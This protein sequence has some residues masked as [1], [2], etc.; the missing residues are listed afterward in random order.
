MVY[1]T[2]PR[3]ADTDG[4]GLSDAVELASGSI[5]SATDPDTDHDGMADGA[6]PEPAT[7]NDAEA[8]ADGD[9]FPLWQELFYGTSD[10]VSNGVPPNCRLVTFTVSGNVPPA[11]V[12]SVGGFPVMAAAHR[13]FS[14]WLQKDT[15]RPLALGNAPGVHVAVTAQDCVA[16]SGATG[17]FRSGGTGPG[18]ASL[19]VPEV[20]LGAGGVL[21]L[22]R[23][24]TG[25][26]ARVTADLPGTFA[27]YL[28]S[29]Y[30][31][32]VGNGP[33]IGTNAVAAGT[34]LAGPNGSAGG[35]HRAQRILRR[36]RRRLQPRAP[37]DRHAVRL[38]HG[39]RRAA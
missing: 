10:T 31:E 8:D 26:A 19:A 7:W 36:R 23:G 11:A 6:D 35:R 39:G 3:R 30:L 16:L 14:L 27:W 1:G 37:P 24:E 32:G 29:R 20:K 33:A 18:T 4:D 2:D 15:V 9:G 28:N 21:C 12:L 34:R 22:H 25:M 17:G 13:Q 38:L 5:T